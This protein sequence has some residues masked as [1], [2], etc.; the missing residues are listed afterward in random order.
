MKPVVFLGPSLPRQEAMAILDADYHPPVK[1]GDIPA[2]DPGVRFIG[3]IDGVFMGEAA[4][5]HREIVERMRMGALVVGG[6]SM[7]ALRAAELRDLGM[8]G[9]G[10]VFEM[11]SDGVIEGDD[12]VA[13][14]FNPETLEAMSEPLVNM[15]VNLDRALQEGIISAEQRGSMID[16]LKAIYFPRRTMQRLSE[17]VTALLDR[18]SSNRLHAFFDNGY[19]DVKKG[20]A[21][22]VLRAISKTP[23]SAKMHP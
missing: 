1:R 23:K 14:T 7:G 11:Y 12:E 19:E 21:I 6:S 18:A 4:V 22:E 10:K 9:V 8:V 17:T 3:I 2:L 16:A 20:D 13:L 5:G 15:R